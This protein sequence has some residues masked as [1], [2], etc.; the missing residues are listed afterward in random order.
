MTT[1]DTTATATVSSNDVVVDLSDLNV[2]IGMVETV[3]AEAAQTAESAEASTEKKDVVVYIPGMGLR[4]PKVFPV[5][6]NVDLAQV[7]AIVTA[8]HDE[9]SNLPKKSV[10]IAGAKNDVTLPKVDR[11]IKTDKSNPWSIFNKDGQDFSDDI[12]HLV[13]TKFLGKSKTVKVICKDIN[14]MLASK[15]FF[16]DVNAED[17]SNITSK[18]D[19]RITQ[20]LKSDE[21]KPFYTATL[22]PK[23]GHTFH[24]VLS[25]VKAPATEVVIATTPVVEIASAA[26][27]AEVAAEIAV[28]AAEVAVDAAEVAKTEGA[29]HIEVEA[30][31]PSVNPSAP[32]KKVG[33][34]NTKSD[35]PASKQAPKSASKKK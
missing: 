4:A 3:I 12:I 18:F 33:K 11:R 23:G 7:I 8:W 20:W 9:R 22:G 15:G 1:I 26:E 35:K 24:S 17:F 6:Y 30:P 34:S 27:I 21:V 32:T 14:E 2:E 29:E 28:V 31:K 25:V 16:G 19:T 5:R 10:V 13:N